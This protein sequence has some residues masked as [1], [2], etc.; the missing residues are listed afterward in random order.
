MKLCL[1][2]SDMNPKRLYFRFRRNRCKK[3]AVDRWNAYRSKSRIIESQFC[4]YQWSL[5]GRHLRSYSIPNDP[6]LQQDW[7]SSWSMGHEIKSRKSWRFVAYRVHDAPIETQARD[8]K[9]NYRESRIIYCSSHHDK[10]RTFNNVWT[11]TY[12]EF[13][14]RRNSDSGP[15][16]DVVEKFEKKLRKTKTKT[17]SRKKK[18]QMFKIENCLEKKQRGPQ[19]ICFNKRAS[20]FSLLSKMKWAKTPLVKL[21]DKKKQDRM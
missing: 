5:V 3:I 19:G 21:L 11:V 2:Y 1:S 20:L 4:G 10:T 14:A 9:E 15:K 18:C 16:T 8:I 7:I 12:G 17:K 6:R 13:T